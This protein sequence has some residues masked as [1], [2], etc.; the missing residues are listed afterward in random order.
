MPPQRRARQWQQTRPVTDPKMKEVVRLCRSLVVASHPTT[1]TSRVRRSIR[2]HAEPADEISRAVSAGAVK[3]LT[4]SGVSN[5][6]QAL[7]LHARRE[8]GVVVIDA[9]SVAQE[10]GLI[11]T[12]A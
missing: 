1:D 10:M 5:R 8:A 2:K 11:P 6:A 9:S 7:A 12:S 4:S 3:R